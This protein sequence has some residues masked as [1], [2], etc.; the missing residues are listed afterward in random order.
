M[1]DADRLVVH[2]EAS[3]K[4]RV[5]LHGDSAGVHATVGRVPQLGRGFVAVDHGPTDVPVVD[6]WIPLDP[7]REVRHV[8]VDRD[9]DHGSAAGALDPHDRAA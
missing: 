9:G 5:V 6:G 3:E 8:A 4:L 1:D 2:I 7:D